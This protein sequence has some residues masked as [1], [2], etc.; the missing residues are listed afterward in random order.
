MANLIASL[1]GYASYVG[2]RAKTD[3]YVGFLPTSAMDRLLEKRSIALL[4][5][6]KRLLP[7]L[8][9]LGVKISIISITITNKLMH[10]SALYRLCSGL[11][12]SECGS[13]TL[14]TW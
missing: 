3:T 4:T 2:V 10:P 12:A 5:L 7:L 14:A 8:S 13:S 11:G 6:S 1:S 9:P